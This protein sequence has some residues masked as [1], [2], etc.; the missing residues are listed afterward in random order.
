MFGRLTATYGHAGRIPGSESAAGSRA[1]PSAPGSDTR[2][3]PLPYPHLPPGQGGSRPADYLEAPPPRVWEAE[4]RLEGVWADPH[5][6]D[7]EDALARLLSPRPDGD[8]THAFPIR[9]DDLSPHGYSHGLPGDRLGTLESEVGL[10][11]RLGCGCHQ[12]RDRG[13]DGKWSHVSSAHTFHTPQPPRKFLPPTLLRVGAQ[14]TE[15][16]PPPSD[17]A[18]VPRSIGWRHV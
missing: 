17:R 9:Q 7:V 4:P 15:P 12:G 1:E 6:P 2:P 3:N 8:E 5:G 13:H 16:R 18:P 11:L 14:A 10:E